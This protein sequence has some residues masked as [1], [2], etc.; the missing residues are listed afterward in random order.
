[1]FRDSYGYNWYDYGARYYDPQLGRWWNIDPLEEKRFW[2]T[3]YNYCQNKPITHYDKTG[4][5]DDEW[6]YNIDTKKL[7]KIGN[8]GG[9]DIQFLR[10]TNNKHIMLGNTNVEGSNI[11]VDE[12]ELNKEESI[13]AVSNSPIN[14][15]EESLENI[16]KL[17]NSNS[18][19]SEKAKEN[20][21]ITSMHQTT[22]KAGYIVANTLM[23]AFSGPEAGPTSKFIVK[24]TVKAYQA[25][26]EIATLNYVKYDIKG[27]QYLNGLKNYF[28]RNTSKLIWN[29]LPMRMKKSIIRKGIPNK[30]NRILKKNIDV[31]FDPDIQQKEIDALTNLIQ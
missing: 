12:Y 23:F 28:I 29:K 10:I 26:D 5:L 9:K 21:F 16:G 18:P 25:L 15:K 4:A 8:L 31:F 22:D 24:N 1:M 19:L 2:L 3:P 7:Q 20:L 30:I 17:I 6:E 14:A 27:N 11:Y 13:V